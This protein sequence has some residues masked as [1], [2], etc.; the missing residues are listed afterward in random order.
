MADKESLRRIEHDVQIE[1]RSKHVMETYV[2]WLQNAMSA[3]PWGN[4]E[5]NEKLLSYT[6]EN[7]AAAVRLIQKLS[8]AKNLQDVVKIQTE[9]MSQQLN[10]FTEQT[11]TIIEI[12]IKATQ[13]ATKR[14]T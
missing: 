6:R 8:Q 12:C 2:S 3:S 11:K 14:S 7:L 1:E 10:S 9:F 4:H 13:D 5:L